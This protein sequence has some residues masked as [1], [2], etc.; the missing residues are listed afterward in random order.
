METRQGR[1]LD[2]GRA[3][4]QGINTRIGRG[5]QTQVLRRDPTKTKHS[6]QAHNY[7]YDE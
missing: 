1:E 5:S 6:F 2:I 7:T 4:G 3:F